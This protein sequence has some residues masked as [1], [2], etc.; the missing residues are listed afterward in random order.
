MNFKPMLA[1]SPK[2]ENLRYPVLVSQK[3]DGI[4]C[5]SVGGQL[6]SRSLKPIPN[7]HA[8]QLFTGEALEGLDGELIVGDPNFENVYQ[9]TNSG[10][11]SV[12]GEPDVYFY[13]FDALPLYDGEPFNER[14]KR[15]RQAAQLL[16]RVKVV[17]QVLIHSE[18]ELL[19]YEATQLED[20][21]EGVMVRDPEGKYKFGRSTEKGGELGK[22]K[23]FEDGEAEIIGFECLYK[24]ENEAKTNALG[25]TERSTHKENLVSQEL[26]GKLTVR[27]VETDVEFDIGSG[28]TFAQRD[29]M[30]KHQDS[31]IGRTVKYK[32]FPIGVK[33]KPRFP[34]FQGFRSQLDMSK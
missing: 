9:V 27:C 12:K 2:T 28:F 8:Q 26:L 18:L 17:D 24:N 34:I 16:P 20:G 5:I 13:V 25:N 1:S 22:I 30:W 6:L 14:F 3:L 4:R 15:V 29:L 19:E 10:V 7:L 33:D 23:R 31:L 11:M 32:H 21:Y